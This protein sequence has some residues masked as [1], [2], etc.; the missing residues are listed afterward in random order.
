[1][2]DPIFNVPRKV[3]SLDFWSKPTLSEEVDVARPGPEERCAPVME[4]F[5]KDEAN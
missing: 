3:V 5:D 1:M 4:S 2:F